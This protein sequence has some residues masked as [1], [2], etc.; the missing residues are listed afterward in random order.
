[1]TF[2]AWVRQR[3]PMMSVTFHLKTRMLLVWCV[4]EG[5]CSVAWAD[6][7]SVTVM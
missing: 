5:V 7:E 4:G 1:M 2:C 3:A 6:Y